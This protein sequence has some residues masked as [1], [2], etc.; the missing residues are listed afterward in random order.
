MS[1]EESDLPTGAYEFPWSGE[2]GLSKLWF[3]CITNKL[4][5]AVLSKYSLMTFWKNHGQQN[6]FFGAMDRCRALRKTWEGDRLACPNFEPRSG[7][8]FTV[9]LQDECLSRSG[10]S[11][12]PPL[13]EK[14]QARALCDPSQRTPFALCLQAQKYTM[15]SF[16]AV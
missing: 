5:T 12:P 4:N 10:R 1:N 11:Y 3:A 6:H 7:V 16:S 2:R 15:P 8:R 14:N 9:R 13:I